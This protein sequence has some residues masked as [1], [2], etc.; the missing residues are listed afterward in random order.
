MVIVAI[1]GVDDIY[2]QFGHLTGDR[3]TGEISRRLRSTLRDADVVGQRGDEAYIVLLPETDVDG[4]RIAVDRVLESIRAKAISGVRDS[5]PVTASAGVA[6]AQA[7]D[8]LERVLG[9]AAA[10]L[11]GAR[12]AGGDRLLILAAPTDSHA[13]PGE[14]LAARD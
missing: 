14:E 4:A 3:V 13:P 8:D 7:D 6:V 11:D 2:D 1:D 9:A 10:A 12:N 5:V